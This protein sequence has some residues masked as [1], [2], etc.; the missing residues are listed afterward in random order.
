[1]AQSTAVK[2]DVR[3]WS[4]RA[5]LYGMALVITLSY[6]LIGR[7]NNDNDSWVQVSLPL[8]SASLLLV[9]LAAAETYLRVQRMQRNHEEFQATR[10]REI[11]LSQRLA[12]QRQS[13]LNQISRAL[14]DKLDV[15][16]ISQ[17]VLEKIA[18]MFEADGV[19]AWVTEKNGQTHFVLKAAF[20][21]RPHGF[22]QLDATDFPFS[23]PEQP[24]N[25]SRP[26]VF[27]DMARETPYSLAN[28]CG[29]ERFVCAV[30]NP[31]VRRG[32]VVGLIA[33][34]YRNPREISQSL[35]AE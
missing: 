4:P 13:T 35:A 31:V 18:Q 32:E 9:S 21:F 6:M 8:S 16:Q 29:R 5:R 30:L 26:L 11:E 7:L 23:A 25:D 12:Y 1:M 17:E 24:C 33:V 2:L 15:A 19:A 34:F 22:E 10:S 14:I 3:E 20:G 27:N 28:V